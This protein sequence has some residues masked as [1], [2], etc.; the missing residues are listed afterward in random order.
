MTFLLAQSGV[1]AL[2]ADRIHF[3]KAPQDVASPYIVISKISGPREKSHDGPV[4]LAH[5]RFQLSAFAI[6]YGV[7]KA[8]IAALQAA[9]DGYKGMM[10]GDDGVFVGGAFYDDENDLDPGDGTGLF[11]VGADYII[12]HNEE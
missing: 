2:V 6:T 11:G 5:P 12:W 8:V 10:G 9:L 1:T 4:G 3:G 7:A